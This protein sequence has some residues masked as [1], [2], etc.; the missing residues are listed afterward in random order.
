[1]PPE[2]ERLSRH[3]QPPSQ[4]QTNFA[5]MMAML[6]ADSRSSHSSSAA[7]RIFWQASSGLSAEVIKSHTCTRN[8]GRGHAV[9][10]HDTKI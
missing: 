4:S 1:M 6:S 8:P 5:T 10:S 3:R 9:A 2:R 7:S